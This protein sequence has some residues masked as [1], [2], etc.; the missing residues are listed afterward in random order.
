MK[1][2][3][4]ESDTNDS[5]LQKILHDNPDCIFIHYHH[6]N[7]LEKGQSLITEA[8]NNENSYRLLITLANQGYYLYMIK[9]AKISSFV[10]H[11]ELPRL[12]IP[13]RD[14]EYNY[15]DSGLVYSIEKPQYNKKPPR[16]LLVIF[17]SMNSP[18][19]TPSLM[20]MF[21]QNFKT[22]TKYISPDTAILRI[23]DLGGV[24]GSYYMNTQYL[25]DNEQNIRNLI[26]DVQKDVGAENT[27]LFG[28]SKGGTAALIY[29]L[30]GNYDC[31]MVDPIVSDDWYFEKY[32]DL[33]FVKNI[34]SENKQTKFKQL[35]NNLSN[36]KNSSVNR[37]IITSLNS[38]Q[39]TYINDT[40]LDNY[41]SHFFVMVN[42]NQYI[43]DHPDVAKQSLHLIT[44][45]LNFLL[46]NIQINHQI[47]KSV[48]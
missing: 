18:I 1:V 37:Y 23:A 2:I 33:H 30:F 21:T 6:E 3:H 13:V 12:W 10:H 7:E 5:A 35:L 11:S 46:N 16:N 27:V 42:D 9:E 44:S 41:G 24:V 48:I 17:S 22:I 39:F 20:R 47:Y 28:A 15:S 29:S 25:K 40:L 36:Q 8:R 14:G 19:Y 4:L 32:N 38:P 34:I 26:S 45:G 43:C 31:L